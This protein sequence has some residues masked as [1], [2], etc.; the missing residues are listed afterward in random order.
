MQSTVGRKL[1]IGR[2]SRSRIGHKS[3]PR[4]KH[5]TILATHREFAREPF[6]KPITQSLDRRL[7][8]GCKPDRARC[9]R[10]YGRP[11]IC[12]PTGNRGRWPRDRP[13]RSFN[14]ESRH[15]HVVNCQGRTRKLK[16]QPHQVG[17]TDPRLLT[18]AHKIN[19][20]HRTGTINSTPRPLLP[21]NGHTQTVP[22][23]P[24]ACQ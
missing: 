10:G 22:Q 11:T 12:R 23:T 17:K 4:P 8:S 2:T 13:L 21:A 16:E 1:R 24:T 3:Q 9:S 14:H 19:T 20:V 15:R 18:G 6:S 5:S 7:K